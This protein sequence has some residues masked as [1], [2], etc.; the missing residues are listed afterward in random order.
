MRY[1]PTIKRLLDLFIS[2]SSLLILSPLFFLIILSI[3]LGSSGS[4]FFRQKRVGRE[5]RP[6]Q[7]L[8]FGSMTVPD[9]LKQGQFEPGDGSRITRVGSFLR[10]TKL[11][12]LPELYNVFNGDMSI[13]GPRP[14]VEKYVR[15]YVKD[16]EAVLEIRPGLSD[17]ASIKYRDEESILAKQPDPEKYYIETILPDKLS[18]ATKY[19]QQI[20]F[21]TDM[22]IMRDT[23][24]RIFRNRSRAKAHRGAKNSFSP[25]PISA[26]GCFG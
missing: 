11:D 8:K 26:L 18:L 2:V 13:V 3:K 19:A 12:E 7:L 10:K 24:Q 14:E 21:K 4:A 9:D 1:F 16:F 15:I 6:F 17:F 25:L 20:S 22:R 23:I 5:F